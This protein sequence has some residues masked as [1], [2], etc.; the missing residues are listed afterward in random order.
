MSGQSTV[1]VALLTPAAL[2]VHCLALGAAFERRPL[3]SATLQS[4]VVVALLTPAAL[5]VH[6]LALGAALEH[7]PG[8]AFGAAGRQPPRRPLL[9]LS[10]CC[11]KR[12]G[13][14]SRGSAAL[15]VRSPSS[16]SQAC[17]NL[18]TACDCPD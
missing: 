7:P 1:V 8:S 4:I 11:N 16:N 3:R 15:A 14:W 10:V 2:T 17:V 5:T 9:S 18:I 6:S 13:C 12:A